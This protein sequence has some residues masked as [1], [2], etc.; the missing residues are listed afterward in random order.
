MTSTTSKYLGR[1]NPWILGA[2]SFSLLLIIVA[3]TTIEALDSGKGPIGQKLVDSEFP[4]PE[5]S[6]F[7][8]KPIT[9]IMT[10]L[11]MAWYSFVEITKT[12]VWKLP[13][14]AQ[15]IIRGLLVLTIVL[16]LYE[17]MYNFM[18]WDVVLSRSDS[19]SFHPDSV[20]NNFPTDKYSMNL[21]FATKIF[22][23][24]LGCSAY[25]L[26]AYRQQK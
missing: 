4:S 19:S 16:S 13:Q 21:V 18:F 2:V 11:V 23:T 17:V 22:V 26:Y 12:A 14:F 8:L 10:L 15:S 5:A 25:A 6:P 9:W 1:V 3:Y 20:V 7:Y 24:V